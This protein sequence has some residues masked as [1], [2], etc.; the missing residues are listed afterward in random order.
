VTDLHK[1]YAEAQS[2][3]RLSRDAPFRALAPT[4]LAMEMVL[5]TL[6]RYPPAVVACSSF[7]QRPICCLAERCKR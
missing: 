1:R 5:F 7:G 4:P 2:V 6:T 3:R